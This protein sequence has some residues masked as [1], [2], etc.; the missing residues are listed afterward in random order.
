MALH[1]RVGRLL[2][3]DKTTNYVIEQIELLITAKMSAHVRVCL[4]CARG[5]DVIVV[6]CKNGTRGWETVP[7]VK[8]ELWSGLFSFTIKYGRRRKWV[9][10]S[11]TI[12]IL[13]HRFKTEDAY[14]V[15]KSAHVRICSLM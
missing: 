15:C 9:Q 5:R 3:S 8:T 13:K 12:S 7:E 2:F 4:Y 10:R 1:L 6:G 11:D 14:R